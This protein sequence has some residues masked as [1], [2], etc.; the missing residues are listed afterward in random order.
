ME[1]EGFFDRIREQRLII[2]KRA[3][4]KILFGCLFVT[5][6]KNIGFIVKQ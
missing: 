1:A 4:S 3:E 2:N 5:H 6:L